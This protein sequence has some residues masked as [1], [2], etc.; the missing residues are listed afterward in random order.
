LSDVIGQRLKSLRVRK[1][2][3]QRE[4]GDNIGVTSQVISNWE[5]GYSYPKHEDTAKLAAVLGTT[6]DF[7]LRGENGREMEGTLPANE[8]DL[9]LLKPEQNIYIDGIL[10]T[11]EEKNTLL[12]L[13]E[14]FHARRLK[15]HISTQSSF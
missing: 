5:R 12:F 7:L 6:T 8:I 15:K 10:L 11:E 3:K 14:G 13:V 4:L 9:I 1:K 2:W